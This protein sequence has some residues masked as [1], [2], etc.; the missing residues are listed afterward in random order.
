MA[1]KVTLR[2]LA[3][4][5][6]S[7]C[8]EL[9]LNVSMGAIIA[10]LKQRI[11]TVAKANGIQEKSVLRKYGD[12][13]DVSE[14]AGQYKRMLEDSLRGDEEDLPLMPS[15]QAQ[16]WTPGDVAALVCNPIYAIEISPDLALPHEPILDETTWIKA[17]VKLIEELGAEAY[18]RNLL[19]V[20]KAIT[21]PVQ[22]KRP[23]ANAGTIVRLYNVG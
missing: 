14:I 15:A 2:S 5:V 23:L 4:Q 6:K 20:L 13:F 10:D 22:S 3:E 1:D 7:A 8:V 18:L 21:F 12:Q 9:G 17:N 19:S 16:G 11:K